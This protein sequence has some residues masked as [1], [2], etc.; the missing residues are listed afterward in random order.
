MKAV[1][2]DATELQVQSMEEIGGILRIKAIGTLPE[3][4]REI[5]SDPIKTKTIKKEERG[6]ILETYENYTE[7][8]HTENYPGEI[9]G[10][11]N[12]KVG[13]ST[14]ER[15]TS[16]EGDMQAVQ[17]DVKALQEGGIGVDTQVFDAAVFVARASA[18]S[19][20]DDEALKVK[21]IYSTWDELVKKKFTA[22]DAGYKFTHQD[23]LY[24]TIQ[25][26]QQF[27]VQWVPGE[28]TES[29]FTRID[30]THAGTQEDPIPY[31]V[32]MEVFENKY[33]TEDGVLYRC[34]RNSGQALHN[35]AAE[36]VGHY[37]EVVG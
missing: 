31:H 15:L 26:E 25:P 13:K 21:A 12:N 23:V 27:Q 28:G 35:K 8:D 9:Y 18:Q 34:T 32:N 11:V 4:L 19:Y 22:T 1:F 24:K 5:F 3:K 37:F 10:V 36:L 14:E 33:Y 20:S 16:M 6:Q 7:Y 29:I 30:E 2:A 17:Q